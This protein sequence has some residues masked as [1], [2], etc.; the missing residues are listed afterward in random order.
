METIMEQFVG[1]D[2]SQ[3]FTHIYLVDNN[4]KTVWQ[5]KCKSTPEEIAETIKSKS[6][7]VI[8]R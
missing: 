6:P 1:L 4:G 3:D 7:Y 2:V 5:G 8:S